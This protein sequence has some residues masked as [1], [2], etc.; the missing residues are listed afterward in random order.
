MQYVKRIIQAGAGTGKTKL[1][2]DNALQL[3]NQGKVLY[4]TYTKNNLKSMKQDIILQEGIVPQK[5]VCKTWQEFL[6]NELAKPYRKMAE[7]PKIEGLDFRLEG[8]IPRRRGVTRDCFLYYF[9]SKNELYSERLA[10]F[11]C[12]VNELVDGKVFNRLQKIY[13]TILID[14][15]QDMNGYDL[16]ILNC[17]YNLN[18]N[19]I[20]VGDN[21]QATYSTNHSRRHIQYKNDKIFNFFRQVMEVNEIEK[22]EIC[23]RCNQQICDFA[24]QLFEN[25]NLIS[26]RT[27]MLSKEDGIILIKTVDELEAYIHRYMPTILSYDKNDLKKLEKLELEV[28]PETMTFGNSK[29]LTRDRVLILPTAEMKKQALG[30]NYNLSPT[31]LAKYYVAVTRARN[32][33]AIYV[34]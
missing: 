29:G 16:D 22:L 31:T 33:V 8:K 23:Y 32:S 20:I 25:L 28:Y 4:L 10:Q 30:E 34:G 17:I 13:T 21:R 5:V 15:I 9:N 12:K 27:E 19:V 3:V 26:A 1:L 11:C 7:M 24:N 14:E 6:Y 18:C 2:I